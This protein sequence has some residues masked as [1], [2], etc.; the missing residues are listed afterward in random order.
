MSLNIFFYLSLAA[1]RLASLVANED[2]PWFMFKRFRGRAEAWCKRYRFCRELGLYEL[3]TCEWCSSIWIG[4]GLTILYLL[5][6]ETVLYLAL[7]LALSTV[8]IVIKYLVEY[9]Q[10]AGQPLQHTSESEK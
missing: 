1:W 7:P 9:L 3:V 4:A 8:A 2:G 10:T 5:I 6:G